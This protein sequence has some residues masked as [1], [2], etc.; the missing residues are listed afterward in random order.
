MLPPG[1][2]IAQD[3]DVLVWEA[4]SQPFAKPL[5]NFWAQWLKFDEHHP[6]VELGIGSKGRPQMWVPKLLEDVCNS[7]SQSCSC[8]SLKMR[9]RKEQ[10]LPMS[11]PFSCSKDPLWTQVRAAQS[12]SCLAPAAIKSWN[13]PPRRSDLELR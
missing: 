11:Q 8:V 13:F 9:R 2:C 6:A 12:S 7:V 10:M 3:M 4:S 1:G 5:V